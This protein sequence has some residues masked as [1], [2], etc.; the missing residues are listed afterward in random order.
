MDLARKL[1]WPQRYSARVLKNQFI[2]RW[3]G[4]ETE[5]VAVADEEA[6]KYRLAW[7]EAIRIGAIPSSAR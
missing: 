5:L 1:P 6:A 3:H 2:E 4:H 7:A